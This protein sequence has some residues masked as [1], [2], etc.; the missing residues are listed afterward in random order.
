MTKIYKDL[1]SNS[2]VIEDA[3]GAQ[4]LNTLQA[5][6]DNGNCSI[7]DIPKGKELVSNEPYSNFI[8]ENDAQWGN[9]DVEVCNA[10]NAI[11]QSSGSSGS[12]LPVITSSLSISL[13]E[14]ESLNY[15]LTAD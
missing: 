6:F 8:D 11:F 12:E 14:G 3:N 5:T 9:S 4:F 7:T 1:A 13:V 15:E 10:L 2:I